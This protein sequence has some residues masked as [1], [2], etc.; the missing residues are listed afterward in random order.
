M[1]LKLC[2]DQIKEHWGIVNKT[3]DVTFPNSMMKTKTSLLRDLMLENAQCWFYIEYDET[4]AVFITRVNDD[5]VVGRK[6]FTIVAMYGLGQ[7]T[8][9]I[10]AEAFETGAKF[11]KAKGCELF[12]FY[13]TN[14]RILH[15]A[16]KYNVAWNCQ[17]VQ[18]WL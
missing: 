3:I 14:E 2:P 18:L 16:R 1:I 13:T 7:I 6:T 8:D 17:Y 15:Y 9:E 12:D 4:L 11:A 5:Y 10:M